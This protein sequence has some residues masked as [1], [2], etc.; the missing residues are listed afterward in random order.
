MYKRQLLYCTC[1]LQPEEGELQIKD[2]LAHHDNLT[3]EAISVAT[4]PQI[5][6]FAKAGAIN[7]EGDVRILP[8]FGTDY[9]GMDGFFISRLRKN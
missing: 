5:A 3:R 8:S 7:K 4:D 2:A 6:P 1:S 9:G